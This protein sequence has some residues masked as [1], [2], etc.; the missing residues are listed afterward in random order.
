MK[1]TTLSTM[2]LALALLATPAI[3]QVNPV[4]FPT[5]DFGRLQNGDAVPGQ[6][7]KVFQHR[8]LAT[9]GGGWFVVDA[10]DSGAPADGQ[11]TDAECQGVN[12]YTQADLA[13]RC[14]NRP[15]RP[16]SVPSFIPG[17]VYR[18]GYMDV[19]THANEAVLAHVLGVALD[20]DGVQ[21]VTVRWLVGEG[22]IEAFRTPATPG[23]ASTFILVK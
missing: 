15:A 18:Y 17:R 22:R 6:P 23:G 10:G 16:N 7:G 8:M 5:V 12:P 3:A 21:V 2:T 14:S 20:V 9:G 1:T 19:T 4:E 13:A 11:P